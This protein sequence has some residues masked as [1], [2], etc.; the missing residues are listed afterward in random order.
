MHPVVSAK[1]KRNAHP[2]RNAVTVATAIS[3]SLTFVGAGVAQ[4]L[5][6]IPADMVLFD[7]EVDTAVVLL[8]VPLCA[9]LLAIIA[10]ALR[11]TI[12]GNLQP[13]EP[14]RQGQLTA[15]KPGHGEG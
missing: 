13:P 4:L 1:A 3:F 2:L 8:T 7:G 6:L 15:W 14:Q 5:G 12:S 10:E 11:A 9:L